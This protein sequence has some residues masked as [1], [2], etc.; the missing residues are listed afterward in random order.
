M[1]LIECNQPVYPL[2]IVRTMRDQRAM[3]IQTPVSI[4]PAVLCCRTI[5]FYDLVTLDGFLIYLF[6]I[7]QRSPLPSVAVAL[8]PGKNKFL[9]LLERSNS[10]NFYRENLKENQQLFEGYLANNDK[11]GQFSAV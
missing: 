7:L 6:I 8:A 10:L 11:K 4:I 3:M 9:R 1:C 5:I 2:D